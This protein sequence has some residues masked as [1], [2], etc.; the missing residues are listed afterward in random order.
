M[1]LK[2]KSILTVVFTI[3]ISTHFFAQEENFDPN[4]IKMT[5]ELICHGAATSIAGNISPAIK[6]N[7]SISQTIQKIGNL[8][9]E[10]IKGSP[11]KAYK[12]FKS[13]KNF[14]Q[15]VAILKADF[16]KLDKSVVMQG[17][18]NNSDSQNNGIPQQI[19]E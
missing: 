7:F 17:L 6:L 12:L 2:M 3:L 19:D 8:V 16:M 14:D 5:K 13:G 11:E 18:I 1:L 10:P 4:N 15:V 9:K